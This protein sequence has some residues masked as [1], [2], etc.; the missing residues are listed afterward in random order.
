MY[1]C[2]LCGRQVERGK[3]Q[4]LFIVKTRPR[5]YPCGSIGWEIVKE[6]KVCELCKRKD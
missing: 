6:L 2:Q 5:T 3:K 1:K 4:H